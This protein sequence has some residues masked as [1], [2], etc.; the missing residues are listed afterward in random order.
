MLRQHDLQDLVERLERDGEFLVLRKLKLC[1]GHTAVPYDG[2]ATF[3]AAVIDV[4]TTGLDPNSDVIIELAMRRFRFD[5]VGRILSIDRVW[6]W[7]EDP[8]RPLPAK[9]TQ[10]TGLTDAGL[11]GQRI[12]EATA[13]RLF[14]SLHLVI[15]HNAAFDRKFVE[16]RLPDAAGL[17]WACSCNEVDWVRAGFDGARNLGWLVFQA[18]LFFGGH[19]ASNDVDAVVA[20][21]GHRLPDDRT[22]LGELVTR[23]SAPS[24]RVEAV[25]ADFSVKADL[26]CRGYRW[27]PDLKV[28]WKEI[29]DSEL[30]EEQGWLGRHVYGTDHRARASGPRIIEVSARE[31][32]A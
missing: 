6:S 18:G 13:V 31:R 25:G 11:A 19:R 9:I 16:R 28:W 24:M 23:S 8:G 3:I 1:E 27:D 30:G 5:G 2:G 14:R 29:V 12:D 4:E 22:V 10:L 32:Y 15:A 7:L 17:P 21:L 26:R 20:L